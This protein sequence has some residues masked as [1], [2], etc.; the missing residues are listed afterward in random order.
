VQAL[1][2]LAAVEKFL[3]SARHQVAVMFRDVRFHREFTKRASEANERC[4]AG[5][6]TRKRAKI[7]LARQAEEIASS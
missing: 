6:D 5:L 3:T 1:G 4:L 2:G 7:E